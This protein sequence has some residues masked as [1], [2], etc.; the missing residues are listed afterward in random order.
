MW[1][2]YNDK[3]EVSD[4]GEVRHKISQYI[5]Q[6]SL[7]HDG[8]MIVGMYRWKTCTT[9][10]TVHRMVAERFLPAPT[11]LHVEV[12][13]ID[14]DRTNNKASNLR[15][16]SHMENCQNK[17]FYKSNTTGYK[18][19]VKRGNS[20]RVQIKD[21]GTLVFNKTYGSIEEAITARDNFTS[22]AQPSNP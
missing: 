8:Y 9:R 2:S 11:S 5:K 20:Y 10:R 13:H 6:P 3:Y 18:H 14:K 21:R 19:I 15:W 4:S 7:S 16:V 1:L 22:S 17:G 12:D